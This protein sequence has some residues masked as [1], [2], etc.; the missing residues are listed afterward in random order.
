VNAKAVEESQAYRTDLSERLAPGLAP[1]TKIQLE[2]AESA[3]QGSPCKA[4]YTGSIPVGAS[5]LGKRFTACQS[6]LRPISRR[7]PNPAD[8]G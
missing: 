5:G 3:A 1:Q 4:V 7:D 6:G 8:S 2:Q